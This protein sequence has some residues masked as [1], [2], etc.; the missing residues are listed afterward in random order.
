MQENTSEQ[1]KIWC[2]F[3]I[4]KIKVNVRCVSV[5]VCLYIQECQAEGGEDK[6]QRGIDDEPDGEFVAALCSW[7]GFH[8]H[9]QVL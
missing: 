2:Y 4:L 7:H 6:K 1:I 3:F 5:C 8:E 9:E